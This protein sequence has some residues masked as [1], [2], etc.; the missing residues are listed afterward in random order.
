MDIVLYVP[1]AAGN[2]VCAVIDDTGCKFDG[3]HVEPSRDRVQF[4]RKAAD[5]LSDNEKDA[6]LNEMSTLYKS[7]PSHAYKYHVEKNHPYIFVAPLNEEEIVWTTERFFKI[8][9]S[10]RVTPAPQHYLYVRDFVNTALPHTDKVISVSDILSGNLI[11]ILKKYVSTPLNE[12][13][14]FKWLESETNKM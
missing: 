12:D 4:R 10:F 9:P 1:G 8:H 3:V 7:L 5:L 6:Y 14:Y 13:L 2:L 11:D